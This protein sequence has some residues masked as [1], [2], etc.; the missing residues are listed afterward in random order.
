MSPT[1]IPPAG[2]PQLQSLI[3]RFI[4]ISVP[5]AFVVLVI[6]LSIAGFKYLTSGG[7]PKGLGSASG[8]I[9]WALLGMLFLVII[10]LVLQLIQAFT[11]VNVTN[12]CLGFKPFC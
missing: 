7:D 5:L 3:D 2:L 1:P 6:M 11:G 10:W 9:T 12:F 4:S 8:T